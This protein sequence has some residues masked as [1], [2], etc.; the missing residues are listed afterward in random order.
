[1]STVYIGIG[2][3][4][5]DRGENCI[6]AIELFEQ[7]GLPVKKK[8]SLYETK[9]WGMKNQPLFLNMAVEIETALS[10]RELLKIL[11]EMEKEIGREPT[12]RWG[13]RII[14]LDILLFNADVVD[15]DNLSIPHPLMHER[16]FVLQPLSEIAP[17]AEHPVL[18]KS[19]RELTLQLERKGK[20]N[21]GAS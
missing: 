13:P 19:I 20:D 7:K 8:S 6:R 5:G 3:N 15:E 16:D 2:S 12:S 9:P 17:D 1:M 18:H 11:K 21:R 4:L 14:D 10:P